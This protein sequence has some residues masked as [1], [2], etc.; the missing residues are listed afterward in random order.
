MRGDALDQPVKKR[1][2]KAKSVRRQEIVE[3]AVRRGALDAIGQRTDERAKRRQQP[4]DQRYAGVTKIG[5]QT[6]LKQVIAMRG[7]KRPAALE[8]PGERKQHVGK[9]REKQDRRGSGTAD[10]IRARGR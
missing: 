10:R 1:V 2:R 8:P 9:D 4:V 5:A 6:D 7:Q 3:A